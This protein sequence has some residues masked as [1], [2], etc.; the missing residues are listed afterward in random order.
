MPSLVMSCITEQQGCFP[1]QS[2]QLGNVP[3]CTSSLPSSHLPDSFTFASLDSLDCTHSIKFWPHNLLTGSGYRHHS[4]RKERVIKIRIKP[5]GSPL[6]ASILA[7]QLTF[8]IS[9]NLHRK[10]CNRYYFPQYSEEL[11]LSEA[12]VTYPR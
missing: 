9:F 10:L 12:L 1:V 5:L 7:K 3:S 2:R 4:S 8:A 6:G 11:R